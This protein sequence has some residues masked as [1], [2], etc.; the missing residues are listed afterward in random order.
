M[1]MI[2]AKEMISHQKYWPWPEEEIAVTMSV[3][4]KTANFIRITGDL[5]VFPERFK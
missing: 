2:S 1:L 3:V 4:A 5:P